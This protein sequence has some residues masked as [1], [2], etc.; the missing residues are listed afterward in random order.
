MAQGI[1]GSCAAD[2]PAW[3]QMF[4]EPMR[5]YERFQQYW[6]CPDFVDK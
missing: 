3:E 2:E 1:G 5:W 4:E 6:A